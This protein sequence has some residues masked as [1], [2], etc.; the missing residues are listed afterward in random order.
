MPSALRCAAECRYDLGGQRHG[1]DAARL[2]RVGSRPDPLLESVNRNL[3]CLQHAM[4][5]GKARPAP[6]FDMAFDEDVLVEAA[7][8]K[9]LR[10]LLHERHSDDSVMSAHFRW[11]LAAVCEQL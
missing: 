5:H 8:Q 3:A 9:E 6:C 7:G 11:R 4:A 10:A 2:L 1:F